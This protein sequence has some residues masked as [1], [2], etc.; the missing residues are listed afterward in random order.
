MEKSNIDKKEFASEMFPVVNLDDD[1]LSKY[2]AIPLTGLASLGAAFAKLPAGART[3]VQT[4]H[5]TIPLR[6]KLYIGLNPKNVA[7][8]MTEN[9]FGT[10][11]N[12]MQI[13]PN[14]QHVIAGRMRFKSIDDLKITETTATKI[15]FD[16][17]MMVVAVALINI[18]KKLDNIQKSVEEILQFLKQEKQSRQRGNLNMLAEIL[19]DYK[20]N[21]QSE[22]FCLS[23]SG[24]VLSIKTASYQDIDFYQNQIDKELQKQK[25]V[26]GSKNA[27]NI[28]NAVAYQFAEYQ[29]ACY[30]YAFSTFLDVLLQKD[31][32]EK[33]IESV[34][35]KM[36]I[37]SERYN[38]LYQN[39]HSQIENYHKSAVGVKLIGG[40]GNATKKLGQVI[41][42]IP[43]IKEGKV[44]ETLIHAGESIDQ[45]NQESIQ[46]RL[47]AFENLETN[48]MRPF[49]ENIQNIGLLYNM[50][51]AMITDGETLYVLNSSI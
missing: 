44:D 30:I 23:R 39:C 47:V 32:D 8:Y 48:R 3:I 28:L 29:L 49:I 35:N 37:M 4:V 25:G 22:S 42:A 12:I 41:G 17:M 27:Q 50:E 40:I 31:F 15:P 36:V 5:K 14:G 38:T 34:A 16:P 20:I 43:V 13:K 1:K 2:R 33:H 46:Q 45:H 10:V 26:H 24:E 18:E 19:E 9:E 6:Q 21:C 7:G 51:N 11:G